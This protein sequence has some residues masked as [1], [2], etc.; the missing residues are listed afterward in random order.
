M[1]NTL[2]GPAS[3]AKPAIRPFRHKQS[4]LNMSPK[5]FELPDIG[6]FEAQ[7][8]DSG[9]LL[10]FSCKVEFRDSTPEV[11]VYPANDIA[12]SPE[13]LKQFSVRYQKFC[14]EFENAM[15][16]F[17]ERLRDQCEQYEIEIGS[18]KDSELVS[19]LEWENIKLDPS[20]VIECY[21]SNAR[22]TTNFDIVLNFNQDMDLCDVDFDG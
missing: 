5:S 6:L 3:F 13:E 17:P 22:V 18:L 10:C 1:V 8:L 2:S 12:P 4:P 19:G 20:G 15:R 11:I 7:F 9:E 16:A 21:A 14:S